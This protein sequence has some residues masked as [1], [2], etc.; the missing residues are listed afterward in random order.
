MF[1]QVVGV[2]FKLLAQRQKRHIQLWLYFSRSR[3]KKKS[4]SLRRPCRISTNLLKGT[5]DKLYMKAAALLLFP[6]KDCQGIRCTFTEDRLALRRVLTPF[7][8]TIYIVLLS[9]SCCHRHVLLCQCTRWLLSQIPHP[10]TLSPHILRHKGSG[11][12]TTCLRT[13]L[14]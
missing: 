8:T 4:L 3:N 9:L 10:H 13:L 12:R 2:L 7:W 1:F 11:K 5:S 14:P 6:K